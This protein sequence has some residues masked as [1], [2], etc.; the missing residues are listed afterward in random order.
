[1][2]DDAVLRR[3]LPLGRGL[4]PPLSTKYPFK[5]NG[6][7]HSCC[8]ALRFQILPFLCKTIWKTVLISL[9]LLQT[10]VSIMFAYSTEITRYSDFAE[11]IFECHNF[12][13]VS[14]M[15]MHDLAVSSLFICPSHTGIE[16]KPMNIGSCG[17]NCQ[18]A[19]EL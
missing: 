6:S 12:C 3:A 9:N 18:V 19:Q 13:H 16:S 1:M 17:L 7:L 10:S 11:I 15:H 8:S 4:G 5:Y 14:A 2:R